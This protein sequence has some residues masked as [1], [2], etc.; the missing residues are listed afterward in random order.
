VPKSLTD[1]IAGRQGY[2]YNEHGRAGNVHTEFVPDEIIERFCLIGPPATHVARLAELAD[3][4]AGHYGL[5]LQH[6]AQ[7]QT[8]AAYG[9]HVIP[10][11][12]Q[13]LVARG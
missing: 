1:Y 11:V 10:F 13:Q 9:S 4:G 5:Y 12:G 6:D 7:D 3:V 8:L 2:D